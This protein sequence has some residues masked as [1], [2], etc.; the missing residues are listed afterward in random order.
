MTAKNKARG[1]TVEREV[2]KSFTTDEYFAKRAWG[3][4]GQALGLHEQV[5]VAV[6]RKAGMSIP[7]SLYLKLQVKRKKSLPK[8]LGFTEHVD[9]VVFRED[10][11]EKYI[12]LR[13]DDFI[14]R[15]LS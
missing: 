3:S 6:Y 4:N 1:N 5:D 9:G 12:M 11:G 13:L 14:G 15:F 8:F 7:G 10:R 2:V